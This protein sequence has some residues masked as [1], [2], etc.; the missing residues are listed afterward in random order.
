M[1]VL[2]DL[3]NLF[4]ENE[5]VNKALERLPRLKNWNTVIVPIFFK[6]LLYKIRNTLDPE[7]FRRLKGRVYNL[8]CLYSF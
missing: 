5:K 4:G 3:A 7:E 6:P 8:F 2:F 1:N